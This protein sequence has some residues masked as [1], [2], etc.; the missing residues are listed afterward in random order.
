M[1][2]STSPNDYEA[3]DFA[4]PTFEP[5]DEDP[6]AQDDN[7][8]AKG[9]DPPAQGEDPPAKDAEPPVIDEKPPAKEDSEEKVDLTEL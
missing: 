9:N 7:P 8:P 5:H 1:L 3:L 4:N 6:P 2:T